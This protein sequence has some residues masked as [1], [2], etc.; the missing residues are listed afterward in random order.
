MKTSSQ[1]RSLHARRFGAFTLIELLVVIAIIAILAAMLLP[2]LSN[3]KARAIRT[4]CLSN[5]RQFGIACMAYAGDNRESLPQSAKAGDWLHDLPTPMADSLV[6]SGAKPKLFY[7]PGLT[8]GVNERDP[9]T[10]W[11]EFGSGRRIVGYGFLIRRLATGN[12]QDTTMQS[13]AINGGKFIGRFNETNNPVEAQLIVDENMSLT[14][15]PPYNFTVPSAN[16]LPENGGAFKPAH[17]TR[18]LPAGGYILYLDSHVG[19]VRFADMKARYH[20]PTSSQPYYFY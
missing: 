16:V 20:A 17:L 14:A 10:H 13:Q 11:W 2:A 18:S 5:L 6:Q 12:Q 1:Q 9:L 7:C 8:A 3:A 19:W 4:K 15:T